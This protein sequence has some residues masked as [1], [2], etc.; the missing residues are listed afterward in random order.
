MKYVTLILFSV[1]YLFAADAC[2]V[3]KL[4]AADCLF[5]KGDYDHDNQIGRGDIDKLT[6]E[7]LPWYLRW[8]FKAFGGTSQIMKECDRNGD[9]LIDSEEALEVETGCLE[10]CDRRVKIVE[11]MKC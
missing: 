8:T 4:D 6:A 1:L 5:S 7:V 2:K 10:E 9:G 3:S 11:L